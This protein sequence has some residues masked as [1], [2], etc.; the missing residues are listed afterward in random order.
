[1][2]FTRYRATR[3][4]S[5]GQLRRTI[6]PGD[7][8]EFDGRTTRVDGR[9]FVVPTTDAIIQQGWLVPADVAPTALAPAAPTSL[10]V[11]TPAGAL[12]ADSA[13]PEKAEEPYDYDPVSLAQM[14]IHVE[15][16]LTR[17]QVE[18]R[19]PY[20][21]KEARERAGKPASPDQKHVW[22]TDW[23]NHPN[24]E[25]TCT[26][27][28][29]QDV[30]AT[31]FR[32]DYKMGNG[33]QLYHYRDHLGRVHSS[34]IELSCPAFSGINGNES[35]E[36]KERARRDRA[37][38]GEITEYV[39]VLAERVATLEAENAQL[40]EASL[41]REVIDVEVVRDLVAKLV[42]EQVSARLLGTTAGSVLDPF[43]AEVEAE[44][45]EDAVEVLPDEPTGR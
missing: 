39:K 6:Q 14:G 4:I 36:G 42:E 16:G 23:L 38:I 22:A 27:C 13:P 1:M 40:R 29:I 5:L 12:V 43:A 18:A 15:R 11:L 31:H 25:K 3:Q 9:A 34:F 44:L 17:E 8:V 33:K 32:A 30:S 37:A 35:L 26:V 24:G 10:T 19:L 45:V 7:I 20:M 21:S 28:G 2:D 41:A